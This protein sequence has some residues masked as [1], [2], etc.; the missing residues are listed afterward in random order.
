MNHIFHFL[1]EL[2][3]EAVLFFFVLSGFSIGLAQKGKLISS[4]TELHQYLH[5]RLKRIIPIYWLALL[6]ALFIGLLTNRIHQPEYSFFNFLGNLLFLQTPANATAYWFSPYGDNGPLWSL[7]YEVFFYLFFPAFGYLLLKIKKIYDK[8]FVW[9]LLFTISMIAIGINKYI[10]FIPHFAFLSLFIVWWGG[11]E[12]AT[13]FII[14]KRNLRFWIGMAVFTLSLILARNY[15]P[16]ASFVEV[17]KGLW[18]ASLLY[19]LLKFNELW[20][21]GFKNK[22]KLI[23]NLTFNRIGHGSYAIYALHYPLLL[24]FSYLNLSLLQQIIYTLVLILFCT[25]LERWIIKIHTVSKVQ[26]YKSQ[27]PKHFE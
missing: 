11:F 20:R 10:V 25:I 14:K 15:F 24:Y 12:I 9:L 16:S 6:L 1:S 13:G 18:I 7:S 27:N 3:V 17:C 26:L 22:L 4:K 23:F 19:F 5:R 21:S 8:R 2:N